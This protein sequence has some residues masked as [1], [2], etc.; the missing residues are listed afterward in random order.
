MALTWDEE[1]DAN[2]QRNKALIQTLNINLAD[3]L[4]LPRAKPPTKRKAATKRKAPP[5]KAAENDDDTNDGSAAPPAKFSRG[6]S[7]S[8]P[9]SGGLRRSSR[10]AASGK[11]TDYAGDGDRL[12]KDGAPKFVTEAARTAT[13]K[14]DAKVTTLRT[15]DPKRY[16]A[17]PGIEVGTCIDCSIDAIHAPVVSGITVG[18]DGAYSVALSGGYEDDVDLG[19]GFTY[20]GSGG[21]DL[22]GTKQNPKN[23]RTAPQSSDQNWD[24]P[25]NA[26]LQRSAESKN[27]VRVIRGFKLQSVFA[28]EEGYRY[29][30]L[31]TVEKAWQ[32]RGLNP[33]GY[34]VCK[35]LFKRLPG[36]PRLPRSDEVAESENEESESPDRNENEE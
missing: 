11:K 24:N 26:A 23:L 7:S 22:K 31:Y 35:F 6:S 21:R 13:I 32:E 5:P 36:Q 14:S 15:Q 18:P 33:Q 25:F 28:P 20:T 9:S 8:D 4:G 10:V 16:G 30:G 17:I 29:D 19:D 27:P 34:L 1:R 3:I 12:V 2:I